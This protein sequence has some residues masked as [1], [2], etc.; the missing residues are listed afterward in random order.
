M[1]RVL[2]RV[3]R[4][5]GISYLV[6][7]ATARDLLLFNVCGYETSRA[8]RDIDLAIAAE[9]WAVVDRIKNR[10]IATGR[11]EQDEDM[12]QR[13]YYRQTPSRRSYPV[14]VVPFGGVADAAQEI[15]WPPDHD[16]HM[17]VMG[18][19]DALDAALL[20]QVADD[21]IIPLPALAGLAALKLIAWKDRHNTD[22]KDAIDFAQIIRVYAD[23]GNQERLYGP[24][25]RHLEA[26]DYDLE[27]A[28]AR[29]LGVDMR[30]LV[31]PATMMDIQSLLGEA[32]LRE[33]LAQHMA[34]TMRA[35]EDPLQVAGDLLSH[36][37]N[38]LN[39]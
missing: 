36:L 37:A 29:L 20:L 21:L 2:D 6:V 25:F 32:G 39:A 27:L 38:G 30:A 31:W 35:S 7:G 17:N 34:S 14:D 12:V 23:A 4:E 5:E 11:F 9:N 13:L 19:V 24:E 18:F 8:T 16:I 26:V 22:S 28:G 33:R 3:L 1:L 15:H 10:L